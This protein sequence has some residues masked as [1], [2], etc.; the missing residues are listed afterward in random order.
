MR[1]YQYC[2]RDRFRLPIHQADSLEELADLV[3]IKHASAKRGFYRVYTGKTKDSR[4]GYV[5][6]PDDDEEDE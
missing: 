4:W 6:I 2:T 3:G 1:V 5:D